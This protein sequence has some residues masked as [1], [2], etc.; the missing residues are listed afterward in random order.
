MNTNIKQQAETSAA[1]EAKAFLL[2]SALIIPLLT[3]IGIFGYGFTIWVMQLF[4][5]PPSHL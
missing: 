4:Y 2:I 3:V 5:G 1:G